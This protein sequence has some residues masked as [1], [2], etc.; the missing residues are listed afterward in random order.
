VIAA[1]GA[2]HDVQLLGER[3]P[4]ARVGVGEPRRDTRVHEQ[5]QQVGPAE[6]RDGELEQKGD[7]FEDAR[8]VARR[9]VDDRVRQLRGLADHRRASGR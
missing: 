8:A 1:I 6:R 4:V 9:R 7:G 3:Q 2:A 5:P